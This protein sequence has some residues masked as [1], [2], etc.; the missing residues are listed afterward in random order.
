[1][2]LDIAYYGNT[3]ST[4][5]VLK[6]INPTSSLVANTE[7]LLAIFAVFALPG[8]VF[9]AFTMDRIGRKA[10]QAIGFAMMA[11]FFL[12]IAFLHTGAGPA[13]FLIAYGMTYFFFE[14]GPNTTTFIYPAEIFPV[15]VRT[16]SHGIAAFSGKIG[17][18]LG[19]FSFPLL[20]A[21]IGLSGTVLICAVLSGA[22]FLITAGLLPEPKGRSLEE[23]SADD[24]IPQG[25]L[26]PVAAGA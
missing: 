13:P 2:I 8:Y 22:G 4:P 17:A 3:L 21:S 12:A 7:T 14:F 24:F 20:L 11:L 26:E 25:G 18:F 15:R 5:L 6:A 19:T 1:M 9:A 23:I 10:I 16:T